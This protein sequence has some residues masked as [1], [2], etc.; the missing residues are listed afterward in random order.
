[1]HT[2]PMRISESDIINH[3]NDDEA[4]EDISRI[5]SVKTDPPKL[6]YDSIK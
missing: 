1:M 4:L 2:N 5:E 3:I 6:I